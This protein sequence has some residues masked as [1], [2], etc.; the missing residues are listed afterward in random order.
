MNDSV[1]EMM[2]GARVYGGIRHQ[3]QEHSI[4]FF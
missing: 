1:G 4:C 3:C 2:T